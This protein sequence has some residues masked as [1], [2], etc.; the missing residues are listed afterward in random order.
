MYFIN[1]HIYTIEGTRWF[2]Y[3]VT[4]NDIYT[5]VDPILRDITGGQ[6]TNVNIMCGRHSTN[7]NIVCGGQPTN[8]N[9]I[10]TRK[11]L[12]VLLISL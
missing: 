6:A 4:Y 2:V 8:V 12:A 7:V 1:I 11:V 5:S 10:Y 3:P 9:I